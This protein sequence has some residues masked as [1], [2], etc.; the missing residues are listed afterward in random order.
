MKKKVVV[1]VGKRGEKEEEISAV[2][3]KNENTGSEIWSDG[4]KKKKNCDKKKTTERIAK[5]LG[6]S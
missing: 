2:F 4:R 6:L 5:E 1:S 3:F